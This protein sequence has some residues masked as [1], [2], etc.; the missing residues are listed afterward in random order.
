MYIYIYIEGYIYIYRRT[1]FLKQTGQY[2]D[3]FSSEA[4]EISFVWAIQSNDAAEPESTRVSLPSWVSTILELRICK[5]VSEHDKWQMAINKRAASGHE[6]TKK[7]KEKYDIWLA[8]NVQRLVFNKKRRCYVSESRQITKDCIVLQL[9]LSETPAD[10]LLSS[11]SSDRKFQLVLLK[12]DAIGSTSKLPDV[13]DQPVSEEILLIAAA[14]QTKEDEQDQQEDLGED[15]VHELEDEKF[16]AEYPNAGHDDESHTFMVLADSDDEDDDI[17]EI[18]GTQTTRMKTFHLRDA[19]VRLEKLNLTE[20]PRH[21]KG[22]FIGCHQT[23]RQWQGFYPG[24]KITMS[25]V[26]GGK[27]KRTEEE[28]ILRAIRGVLESHLHAQPKDK[29][30]AKQVAKLKE[31]EATQSF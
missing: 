27:T 31:A 26:W 17:P 25:C 6:L 1:W 19:W 13:L 20:M 12:H 10:L 18:P 2:S 21:V 4:G 28:A 5:F 23:S 3:E 7:Q 15:Q 22:C 30:W 29:L 16:A 9:E 14:E 8:S 24:S 11:G